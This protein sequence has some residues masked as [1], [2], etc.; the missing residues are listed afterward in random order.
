M[1]GER[2]DTVLKIEEKMIV[3]EN[4]EIYF[5][6]F[7]LSV[8]NDAYGIVIKQVMNGEYSLSFTIPK[9]SKSYSQVQVG[10][11]IKA[12]DTVFIIRSLEEMSQ[13]PLL[14]V[15]IYCEHILFELLDEFKPLLTHQNSTAQYMLNSILNGTRFKGTTGISGAYNLQVSKGSKLK[16]IDELCE[17]VDGIRIPANMPDAE[18]FFGINI[19]GSSGMEKGFLV[20]NRKNLS[21]IKRIVDGKNIITRLFVYGEEGLGIEEATGSNGLPYIDS[22]NS[23]DYPKPKE[24]A[25]S[26]DNI[27]EANSLYEAGLKYLQT[28]SKPAISYEIE[29]EALKTLLNTNPDKINIGDVIRVIDEEL[30][31]TVKAKVTELTWTPERGNMQVSLEAVM[32]T[33]DKVIADILGSQETETG[34]RR[35]IGRAHV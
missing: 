32:P 5:N 7:G 6:S 20:H 1:Y 33:I 28:A 29:M 22:T 24:G 19:L 23:R 4:D 16:C 21:S 2:G 8:I 34:I 17:N 10:R 11:F 25:V 9:N 18:G 35:E 13:P 27:N 15:D 14:E 31:V 3:Y 12:Y 26:F 30:D